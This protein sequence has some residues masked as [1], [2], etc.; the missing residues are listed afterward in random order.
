VSLPLRVSQ[1]NTGL[2][3]MAAINRR[4]SE[5]PDVDSPERIGRMY[6]RCSRRF[7]GQC[8]TGGSDGQRRQR[9][10]MNGSGVVDRPQYVAWPIRLVIFALF[11]S[12]LTVTGETL[13]TAVVSSTLSP[14]KKRISTTR[15]LRASIAAPECIQ[16]VIER[17]EIEAVLSAHPTASSSETCDTPPPRFRFCRRA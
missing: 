8:S 16:R 11:Q 14:P 5:A 10:S 15:P 1:V 9:L 17:D 13:S 12:R 4:A 6:A 3:T 2:R 7:P